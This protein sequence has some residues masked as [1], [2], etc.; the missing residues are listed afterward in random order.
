[1]ENGNQT[2]TATEQVVA[3]LQTRFLHPFIFDRRRFQDA[4]QALITAMIGEHRVWEGLRPRT[5]YVSDF[6]EALVTALFPG[7]TPMES[8]FFR[9]PERPASAWF[10]DA[11]VQLPHSSCLPVMIAEGGAIELFLTSHGTGVLSLP[12]TPGRRDLT[13][14]EALLFN[15]HIAQGRAGAVAE[16]HVPHPAD[17][18]VKWAQMLVGARSLIK[19]APD[20]FAPVEDRLGA[21]GGSFTLAELVAK[22][23]F[24]LEA[25]AL[26]PAGRGLSA[27][28]V[29]RVRQ[30]AIPPDHS[31]WLA[32]LAR[33]EEQPS[34]DG[35]GGVAVAELQPNHR[36]A[37]GP[38][39]VTHWL[40]ETGEVRPADAISR[41]TCARDRFFIPYLAAYFQ[42]LAL[43]RAVTE[44]GAIASAPADQQNARLAGL[45]ARLAQFGSGSQFQ[46]ISNDEAA[47]R[48]YTL[49]QEGFKIASTWDDVRRVVT[50][51]EGQQG[52][53]RQARAADEAA[54]A[55]QSIAHIRKWTQWTGIF[56]FAILVSLW[57]YILTNGTVVGRWLPVLLGVIALGAAYYWTQIRRPRAAPASPAEES[58]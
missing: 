40:E 55:A 7:S 9:V 3:E 47:Q 57:T 39:G 23:L 25:F 16:L 48:A 42:S 41:V 5:E 22:L 32:A 14:P 58:E 45:R 33:V 43:H 46:Q 36:M 13:L 51:I 53:A 52:L 31:G 35:T 34:V 56:A 2:A 6:Q 17:D 28:A 24:P 19:P 20:R 27:Y 50:E 30:E 10:K 8:G 54:A 37:V 44:A 29:A 12:L 15:H 18:Q 1:M 21:P 49:C 26:R 4:G 38:A 11:F